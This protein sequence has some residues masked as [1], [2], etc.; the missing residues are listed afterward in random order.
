M[1][2][3]YMDVILIDPKPY[4]CDASCCVRMPDYLATLT[5][6]NN[7]FV[8]K[9]IS[10]LHHEKVSPFYNKMLTAWSTTIA[11]IPS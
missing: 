3:L 11:R 8:H 7:S 6:I 5:A 2:A 4:C 1:V 10:T 9:C